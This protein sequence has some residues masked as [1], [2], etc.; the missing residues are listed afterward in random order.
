[1]KDSNPSNI[2]S[3]NKIKQRLVEEILA[4]LKHLSSEGKSIP[5]LAEKLID[6]E[7]DKLIG[8][9]LTSDEILA[10][11]KQMS[12]KIHP[13]KP[14]TV[15]LLHTESKK[16]KWHNFLGPVRLVR[17]L[18]ATTL[19]CLGIFIAVGL[20]PQVNAKDLSEGILQ[21]SGINLLLV[22]LFLL[23]AAALG[24]CFSALFQIN[25]YINN[26]TY[27]PQYESSYWIRLLLG[28]ISGL[29]LAVIIPVSS[30]IEF[31]EG[32]VMQLTI[33][34]LAMLGGFS[35]TLAYRILTRIVWAVES[36][37]IG[38]QDDIYNQK[39][40]NM[41]TLREQEKIKDQQVFIQKLTKIKSDISMN[42][43]QEQIE[44][45]IEE[46]MNNLSMHD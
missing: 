1:M 21:N 37:F 18:M 34:L 27:D 28:L 5:K 35:A 29:M 42:K 46:I 43:P 15:L 39:L 44:K 25:K 23:S 20:S 38:K 41:Q 19:I 22:L 33:P 32:N 36:L 14:K 31:G 3:A 45:T 10:L 11:H 2:P 16:G 9:S 30:N 12:A 24:G 8:E 40:E 6:C 26:G 17:S 13:A 7:D 4:M